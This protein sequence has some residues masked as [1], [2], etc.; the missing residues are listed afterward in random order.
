VSKT[1]AA[2][3]APKEAP[4]LVTP[5]TDFRDDLARLETRRFIR[6]WLVFGGCKVYQKE[7]AYFDLIERVASRF[8]V[9]PTTVFAVGSAKLGFSIAPQKRYRAF[10]N[11]S[12]I[13]VVIVSDRLFDRLWAEFH[14]AKGGDVAWPRRDDFLKYLF[15]GWLR[16]DLFPD[17][18][19]HFADG[20]WEFFQGLSK[21]QPAKVTGA[22]YRTWDFFEAYQSTCVKMCAQARMAT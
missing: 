10:N 21:D 16:P 11:E 22:I 1:P 18:R 13:D 15:K 7:H 19:G 5:P 12:D 2:A 6:K 17:V 9:H 4:A 8:E 14:A 20:W 3:L